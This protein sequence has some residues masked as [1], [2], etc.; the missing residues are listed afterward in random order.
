MVGVLRAMPPHYQRWVQL[1]EHRGGST[2]FNTMIASHPCGFTLGEKVSSFLA[3]AI[4]DM[5]EHKDAEHAQDA[6]FQEHDK[7]ADRAAARPWPK[8]VNCSDRM[9][10]IGGKIHL[11]GQRPA[12]SMDPALWDSQGVQLD[13]LT[14]AERLAAMFA[15]LGARGGVPTIILL[16]NN[17]LDHYIAMHAA[18]LPG[19]CLKERGCNASKD[20]HPHLSVRPEHLKS[21]RN[22]IATR[23]RYH[24]QLIERSLAL[25]NRYST[26]LLVLRYEDAERH[27]EMF[28]DVVL[29]F[30]GWNDWPMLH[31]SH[32]KRTVVTHRQII[33]NY[34][35][36]RGALEGGFERY[37][38]RD[39]ILIDEPPVVRRAG[40][41]RAQNRVPRHRGHHNRTHSTIDR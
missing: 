41:A 8:L 19:N 37:L 3:S 32:Q 38:D 29:P 9:A 17:S 24:E 36:V 34:D 15:L 6:A 22:Y 11:L 23:E 13:V 25:A 10:S 21:L 5:L 35:A 1:C 18:G 7:Y 31:S 27:P 28:R 14:N 40:P 12:L 20:I 33:K 4:G 26:P 16:R 2:W 30:L 39:E